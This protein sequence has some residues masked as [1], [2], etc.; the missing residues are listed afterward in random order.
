MA[1]SRSNQTGQTGMAILIIVVLFGALFLGA[2]G[3]VW[4][5]IRSEQVRRAAEVEA[6]YQE[7]F[8]RDQAEAATRM[9][10]EA[11]NAERV[12]REKAGA[13][14]AAADAAP[15]ETNEPAAVAN[16]EVQSP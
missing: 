6:Q 12:E 3:L 5:R 16:S 11:R 10:E 8:A 7:H 14:S 4:V 1:E 2:G 9:A 13:E 15:A